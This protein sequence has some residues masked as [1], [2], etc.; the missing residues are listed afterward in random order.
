[1]VDRLRQAQASGTALL[2]ATHESTLAAALGAATFS[3]RDPDG[4]AA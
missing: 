3:L 1:V 4:C 2:I